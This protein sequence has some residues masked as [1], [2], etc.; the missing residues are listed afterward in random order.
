M[1]YE[2]KI[3]KNTDIKSAWQAVHDLLGKPKG[4]KNDI[5]E[6][7]IGDTI[8]TDPIKIS[9]HFN[10]FFPQLLI[11]LSAKSHLQKKSLMSFLLMK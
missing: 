3:E 6:I 2:T 8:S 9:N 4:K 11:K 7:E 5:N 10:N 1:F